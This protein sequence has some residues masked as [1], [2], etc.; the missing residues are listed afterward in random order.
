M[1]LVLVKSK[2]EL[3]SKALDL[4]FSLKLPK[5]QHL[6]DREKE[7]L[8]SMIVLNNKG[9]K[10]E[11]TEMVKLISEDMGIKNNDVYN[12]RNILKK[13]GWLIQTVDG[14]QLLKS[15]DY[16]S[17]PIPNKMDFKISIKS[18]EK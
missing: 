7:F 5:D 6:K 17:R 2:K 15:L 1:S 10:L 11:S 8:I 13:K 3:L 9:I 12:Y 18:E 14:L 4:A 16:S